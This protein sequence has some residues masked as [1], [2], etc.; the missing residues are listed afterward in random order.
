M[1]DDQALLEQEPQSVWEWWNFGGNDIAELLRS[2]Y[3]MAVVTALHVEEARN[4]HLQKNDTAAKAREAINLFE[5]LYRHVF[6]TSLRII[7]YHIDGKNHQKKLVRWWHHDS[8]IAQEN[9]RKGIPMNPYDMSEA[10]PYPLNI[11][12]AARIRAF[13]IADLLRN[14]GDTLGAGMAEELG[15]CM[16]NLVLEASRDMLQREGPQGF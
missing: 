15:R 7:V 1:P 3:N 2:E 12:V 11:L 16:Y 4:Y 10:S 9:S 8:I 6:Q 13:D 14:R 5:R